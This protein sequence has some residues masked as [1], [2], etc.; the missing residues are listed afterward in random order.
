MMASDK[1]NTTPIA[2]KTWEKDVHTP[3]ATEKLIAKSKE[4]PFVPIGEY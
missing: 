4:T 2:P 1:V 3:T